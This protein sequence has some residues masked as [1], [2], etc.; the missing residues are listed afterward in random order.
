MAR[1]DDGAAR[2]IR[3]ER[4]ADDVD[5]TVRDPRVQELAGPRKQARYERRPRPRGRR[6]VDGDDV[7][8]IYV[9]GEGARGDDHY[10]SR[11]L[12]DGEHGI[13]EGQRR[14]ESRIASAL[15]ARAPAAVASTRSTVHRR[16]REIDPGTLSRVTRVTCVGRCVRRVGR[17][18][19]RA[20]R[21]RRGAVVP[22]GRL[23]T[24]GRLRDRIDSRSH[25]A[26]HNRTGKHGARDRPDADVGSG[27]ERRS[28]CE[29]SKA[30]AAHPRSRA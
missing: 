14:D 8:W 12:A 18:C 15:P 13:R 23:G 29:S 27:V 22:R 28:C 7:D 17:C 3:E 16:C 25:A 10:P 5:R 30:C 1:I 2:L 26:G 9:A 20:A 11:M 24:G 19:I 21:R 6:R 4:G